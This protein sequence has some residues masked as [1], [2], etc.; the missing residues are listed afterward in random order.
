MIGW[1]VTVFL[2]TDF[3]STT[4]VRNPLFAGTFS[5]NSLLIHLTWVWM[6]VS[7]P[8]NELPTKTACTIK[9]V[10]ERAFV[11][12]NTDG[13][14]IGPT[15]LA[16]PPNRFVTAWPGDCTTRLAPRCWTI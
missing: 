5:G 6:F 7:R 8:R 12:T 13:L 14:A 4:A 3:N 9:F 16:P 15:T 10:G 2:N 11:R 1:P